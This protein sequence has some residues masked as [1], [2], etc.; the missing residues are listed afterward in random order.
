MIEEY[1][2]SFEYISELRVMVDDQRPNRHKVFFKIED[3][4]FAKEMYN[5]KIKMLKEHLE[6]IQLDPE[7][8][9]PQQAI[10][11]GGL[12]YNMFLQIDE[13]VVRHYD[14]LDK[15]ERMKRGKDREERGIERG[16]RTDRGGDRGRGR[17][18]RGGRGGR[19]EDE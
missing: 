1:F 6:V 3:K 8:R 2:S 16:D 13:E 5:K 14:R 10:T 12:E 4:E 17:G 18:G 9:P 11:E 15:E 19:F 7:A